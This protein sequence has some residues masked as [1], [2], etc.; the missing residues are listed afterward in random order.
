MPHSTKT[1]NSNFL[2]KFSLSG[3]LQ[4]DVTLLDADQ[5]SF[6]NILWRRYRFGFVSEFVSGWRLHL[7]GDFDQIDLRGERYERLTDAYIVWQP[8]ESIEVKLLKQ[9]AGFTMDG[10][11]SSKKLLTLERNNLTRSLWFSEEYFTG[12]TLRRNFNGQHSFKV[13][14]FS[15]DDSN[16]IGI[17]DASYFLLASLSYTLDIGP[18]FDEASIHL[19]YV[20]NDKDLNAN[21]PDLSHIASFYTR[22]RMGPWNLHTDL[23]LGDGYFGQSDLWGVILMPFYDVSEIIQFIGRYT[24]LSSDQNGLVLNRY[25]DQ[26]VQGKGDK[27]HEIYAGLN[28]YFYG[29]KLKWQTGL[30]YSKMRDKANDGGEYK[31]WGLT[32]GLR[33]SW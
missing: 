17:T 1:K 31:G 19:D 3:R 20:Y 2:K 33:L 5:G 32:T 15:S 25:E 23:A 7:E 12:I 29:H 30:Q 8:N 10:A 27:Y 14:L 28:V 22:W 21:T 11:T 16:E 9:S 24:Y 13:G 6:D 26:I 18:K 4:G